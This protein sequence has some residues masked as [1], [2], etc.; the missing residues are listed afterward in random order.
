MSEVISFRLSNRNPREA[1]VLHILKE[2]Q[3]DGFSVR[4]I[5]IEALLNMPKIGQSEIQI[6]TLHE[7]HETLS[8]FNKFLGEI[9]SLPSIQSGS[10]QAEANLTDAFLASVK[11]AVKP[12]LKVQ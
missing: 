10:K 11:K 4:Q 8:Q 6:T 3:A 12:G 1:Q 5:I 7:L 9:N 2:R